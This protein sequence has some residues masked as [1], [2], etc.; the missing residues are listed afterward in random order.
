M[1]TSANLVE[2][3]SVAECVNDAECDNTLAQ[4][5]ENNGHKAIADALKTIEDPEN[6]DDINKAAAKLKFSEKI[7]I[8]FAYD[9]YKEK[10][11][12]I[13]KSKTMRS[14]T[15]KSKIMKSKIMK[16]SKILS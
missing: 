4:E 16:K 15:M 6:M 7:A 14:K 13:M 11:T 10:I 12:K 2:A 5:L 8:K 3:K 1:L 9:R